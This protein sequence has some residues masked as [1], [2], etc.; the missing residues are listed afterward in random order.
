MSINLDFYALMANNDVEALVRQVLQHGKQ[1]EDD[2]NERKE[3][4]QL[5]QL[6][7]FLTSAATEA[8]RLL[9]ES[10]YIAQLDEALLGDE[11]FRLPA[12]YFQVR[13]SFRAFLV[14]LPSMLF[15]VFV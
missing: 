1:E 13:R 8:D 4:E 2:P 6:K 9:K 14:S 10:K 12:G 15:F 11:L 5:E 7:L 3:E